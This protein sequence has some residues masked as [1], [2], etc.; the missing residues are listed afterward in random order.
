LKDRMNVEEE[1]MRME[2]W[3]YSSDDIENIVVV[4]DPAVISASQASSSANLDDAGDM[5]VTNEEYGALVV[6]YLY[7]DGKTRKEA[8]GIRNTSF[9][10]YSLVKEF[11]SPDYSVA[12]NIPDL[13]RRRTLYWNPSVKTNA[14]GKAQ[15]TFFNNI[16]ASQYEITLEGFSEKGMPGSV[17]KQIQ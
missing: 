17:T 10:G 7:A 14:E 9:E 12:G 1:T 2:E 6:Y 13:D 5:K 15:V 11:F 8:I 16:S 3:K 4:D